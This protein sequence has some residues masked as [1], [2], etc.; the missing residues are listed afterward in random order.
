MK[1]TL[2]IGLLQAG[3]IFC[4]MASA[5]EIAFREGA[6]AYRNGG[7]SKAVDF[8]T[9]AA[10]ARPSSGTLQNLG[11][12]EWQRGH[13]GE[14]ILAWEQAVWLDPFN[15]AAHAN[16]KYARRLAQLEAPD[17]TWYEAVSSG[18]PVNWW[19]W[20]AA[21]SFWI[22]IAAILLPGVFRRPR[23]VGYQ[24]V[25]ALS[26]MLFLLTFLAHFGVHARSKVGFVLAKDTHL[27]LTPTHE[28]QVIARLQP[29]DP[30][31][32]KRSRGNYVLVHTGHATGWLQREQFGSLSG[33]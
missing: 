8:F 26:L 13:T 9:K 3:S 27:R 4:A 19:A 12:S 21:G 17:L 15:R 11:L 18:L 14:A 2:L 32:V 24:A 23:T 25:A 5:S 20:L 10:Q 28:A 6:D 31:R 22:A 33:W 7:Y 1:I 29:G 30:L 16:L